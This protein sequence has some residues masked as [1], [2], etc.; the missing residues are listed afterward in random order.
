MVA[1]VDT[2]ANTVDYHINFIERQR[3]RICCG[4]VRRK[5]CHRLV[6]SELLRQ[7]DRLAAEC[8]RVGLWLRAILECAFQYGWRLHELIPETRTKN[9]NGNRILKGGCELASATL[10]TSSF[11]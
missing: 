7:Y 5:R 3:H 4:E 9:K 1:S 2:T 6:G 10:T 8:G 11:C